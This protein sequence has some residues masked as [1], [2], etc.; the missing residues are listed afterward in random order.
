[1][2]SNDLKNKVVLLTGASGGVGWELAKCLAVRGARLGLV[3]R[4]ESQLQKLA[5]EIISAG[6]KT[7]VVLTADLSRPGAAAALVVTALKTLERID[8]LVNNAGSALQGLTWIA[9]DRD[10]ARELFETNFW[11]PLALAAAI[12]PKMQETGSG[13]ILNVGSM[14]RVSPF[15]HLGH[16]AAS[17]A[18]ISTA[19]MVMQMELGAYGVRVLEFALGPIDS[20]ASRETAQLKGAKR[21]LKGPPK[22]ST[23]EAAAHAITSA[24]LAEADGVAYH[25]KILRWIDRFPGLGR[26]FSRRLASGAD[27]RDMRVRI[28]GSAGDEALR[29]VH[30]VWMLERDGKH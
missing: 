18:A 1:M 7:P 2:K 23:V 27:L 5:D 10:E 15:P 21:W 4:R 8:I 19:T 12:A 28:A 16:Y 11:S 14:A 13:L 9:G 20:P 29:Q 17:R 3:A 25:P 26:R 22:P 24:I 30:D 6:G